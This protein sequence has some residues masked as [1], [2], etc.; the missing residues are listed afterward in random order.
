MRWWLGVAT[1]AL[2]LTYLGAYGLLRQQRQ[3]IRTGRFYNS[4]LPS[5]SLHHSA[6]WMDSG[7]RRRDG[8]SLGPWVEVLFAP[9][10]AVEGLFWDSAGRQMRPPEG[11]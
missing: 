7:V 6:R 8:S 1:A 9:L 4:R 3:L 11:A 10:G 5:G 2:L